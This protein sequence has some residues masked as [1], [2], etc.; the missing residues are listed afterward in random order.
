MPGSTSEY[1]LPYPIGSDP[2]ANGDDAIEDLAEAVE[3]TLGAWAAYTPTL[4]NVTIGNGTISGRYR[5]DGDTVFYRIKLTIG[6]TTSVTGDIKLGLPAATALSLS[7]AFDP[8]GQATLTDSSASALRHW[9]AVH[10]DTDEIYLIN[11]SGTL[12][13][14][15]NPWTWAAADTIQ[16]VGFYEAA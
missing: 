1:G 2:F 16:V 3:S 5:R 10:A 7:T 11:D 9:T 4:G 13:D 6:S 12:A 15:S 8:R 14:A